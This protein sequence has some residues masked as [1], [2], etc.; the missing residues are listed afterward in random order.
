MKRSS[1]N[2]IV[3]SISL[4]VFVF[5]V[6]TGLVMEYILPPGSGGA[7]PRPGRGAKE[8]KEFLSLSRHDWGDIHFYLAIAFVVLMVVHLCLHWSWVKSYLKSLFAK[9]QSPPDS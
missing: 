8:I 4:V 6:L 2:F 5:M 9:N 7:G 3:D 1:I